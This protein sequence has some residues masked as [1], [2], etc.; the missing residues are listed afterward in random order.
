MCVKLSIFQPMEFLEFFELLTNESARKVIDNDSV[1]LNKI[2]QFFLHFYPKIPSSSRTC[3][4]TILVCY[5]KKQ[6]DKM[7][8]GSTASL[9]ML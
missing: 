7:P 9:T 6:I 4:L 8:H 5:C 2:I 1:R 3:R